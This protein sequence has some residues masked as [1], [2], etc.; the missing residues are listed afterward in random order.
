MT[1]GN[2]SLYP[3]QG[4]IG[5][6]YIIRCLDRANALFG[7]GHFDFLGDFF[8]SFL[9]FKVVTRFFF[10]SFLCSEAKLTHYLIT[11]IHTDYIAILMRQQH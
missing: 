3:K 8:F 6:T 1:V 7:R 11:T 9:V 2:L 5:H 4:L 10:V